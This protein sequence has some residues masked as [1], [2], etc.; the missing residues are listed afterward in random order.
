MLFL[1]SKKSDLHTDSLDYRRGVRI[2][3]I[4]ARQLSPNTNFSLAVLPDRF[5]VTVRVQ[6]HKSNVMP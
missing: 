1:R 2:V 3:N 4:L 5:I 6:E